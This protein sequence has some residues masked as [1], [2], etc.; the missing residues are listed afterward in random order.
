KGQP[1]KAEYLFSLLTNKGSDV[2]KKAFIQLCKLGCDSRYLLGLLVYLGDESRVVI[3]P[4]AA[5]RIRNRAAEHSHTPIATGNLNE[6][7][8]QRGKTEYE[9]QLRPMDSLDVALP[10]FTT[11]DLKSLRVK[12]EKLAARLEALQSTPLIR[13]GLIDGV[14][15]NERPL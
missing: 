10:G 12:C 6:F 4:T 3:K 5:R 13:H 8:K 11:R 9:I 7:E 1:I 14:F 2:G 15:Q